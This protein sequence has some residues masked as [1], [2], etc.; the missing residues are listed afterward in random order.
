MSALVVLGGPMNVD[1][2]DTYPNLQ[3][4]VELIQEGIHRQMPILGICLGSQLIAKALGA[5]VKPNPAK[6]IGWY[7]V[8]LTEEGHQDPV[9]KHFADT[10]T[11]FQWHGDTFDLPSNCVHLANSALCRNQAFRYGDNVYALQFHLEVDEPLI[12]RWL[13]EPGNAAE[14]Q[15]D[16]SIDPQ[17]IREQTSKQIERLTRLSNLSFTE[18]IKLCGTVRK[19]RVLPSR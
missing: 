12:N 18:F 15:A 7:D 9:F 17:L 1:E 8:S 11:L 2:T 16:D 14:I 10:E 6:E 4:E 19:H 5:Q 3:T 13:T